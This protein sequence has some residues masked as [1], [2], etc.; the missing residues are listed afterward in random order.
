MRPENGTRRID[1]QGVLEHMRQAVELRP[2]QDSAYNL[3]GFAYRKLGDYPAALD[4]YGKALRLNPYNRGAL[5][6]L[7]EAYLELDRPDDAK[8]TLDRLADAC[9]RLPISSESRAPLFRM[10]ALRRSPPHR[11]TDRRRSARSRA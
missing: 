5:E 10:Q 8:T 7:G 2:W 4:A 6:Y 1:W 11:P 9:R 3:M